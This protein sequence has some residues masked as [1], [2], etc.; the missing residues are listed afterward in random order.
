MRLM[1]H[2][3]GS[4]LLL[5]LALLLGTAGAARAQEEGP[6]PVMEKHGLLGTWAYHC[7]PRAAKINP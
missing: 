4:A 6:R 3:S 1:R 7:D 2:R 5:P